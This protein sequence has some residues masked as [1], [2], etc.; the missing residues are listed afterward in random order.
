MRR[1]G[2]GVDRCLGN[3]QCRSDKAPLPPA[4]LH[5]PPGEG[6]CRIAPK[7]RAD[8]GEVDKAGPRVEVYC[9]TIADRRQPDCLRDDLFGVLVAQKQVGDLCHRARAKESRIIPISLNRHAV[10]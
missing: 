4:A 7:R 5:P 2:K 9:D 6:H 1:S 3:L 10:P 8:A